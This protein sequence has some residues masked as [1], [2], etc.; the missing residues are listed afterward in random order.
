[1]FSFKIVLF[2]NRLRRHL[3]GIIN[4]CKFR[5]ERLVLLADL[6]TTREELLETMS[7]LNEKNEA[8]NNRLS[9][10]REQTF[11]ESDLISRL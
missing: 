5:E 11:D 4:F 8:L 6:S 7:D 10:L 3:S 2:P 1:M 9:L